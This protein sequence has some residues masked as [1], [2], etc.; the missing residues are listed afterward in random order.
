MKIHTLDDIRAAK[1][2]RKQNGAATSRARGTVNKGLFYRVG[3]KLTREQAYYLRYTNL[4]KWVEMLWYGWFCIINICKITKTSPR[5]IRSNE[6][7]YISIGTPATPDGEKYQKITKTLWD[8]GNLGYLLISNRLQKEHEIVGN[9]VIAGV[10][11]R[12]QCIKL[13]HLN[14][15][16]K[17]KCYPITAGVSSRLPVDVLV[18]S[19][20][21][22]QF[23]LDKGYYFLP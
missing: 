16:I 22:T 13:V 17:G 6:P 5:I 8:S 1:R 14:V 10:G 19:T 7:V 11:G 2:I 15:M 4:Y 3:G 18:N 21:I 12:S 20:L 9:D 23:C